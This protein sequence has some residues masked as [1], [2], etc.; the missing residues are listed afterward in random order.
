MYKTISFPKNDSGTGVIERLRIAYND[1]S[2]PG[3]SDWMSK[4]NSKELRFVLGDSYSSLLLKAE[5]KSLHL[6][7]LARGP[8]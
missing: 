7:D 2:S 1:V 4:L 6:S 8:P 3:F 5:N